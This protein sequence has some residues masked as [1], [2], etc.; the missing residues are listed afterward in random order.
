MN[1]QCIAQ[2]PAG[3]QAGGLLRIQSN[4]EYSNGQDISPGHC[5]PAAAE[6]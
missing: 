2:W 1:S 4:F 5:F 3:L 6:D